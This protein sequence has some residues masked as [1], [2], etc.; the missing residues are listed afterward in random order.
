MAA[1][2]SAWTLPPDADTVLENG[3]GAGATGR[4]PAGLWD[5]SSERI[6]ARLVQPPSGQLN[7]G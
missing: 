6:T 5:G 2:A 3:I 1:G 4:S 7:A